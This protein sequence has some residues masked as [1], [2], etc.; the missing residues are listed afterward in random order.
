VTGRQILAMWEAGSG[1]H[2]KLP[3][4][5]VLTGDSNGA[6]ILVQEEKNGLPGAILGAAAVQR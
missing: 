2:F 4:D 5:E 1:A 3:L 6:A